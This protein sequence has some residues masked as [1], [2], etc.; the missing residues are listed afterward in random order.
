MGLD[1]SLAILVRQFNK[2]KERIERNTNINTS[3]DEDIEII[4]RGDTEHTFH[5]SS[6]IENLKEL[7]KY[8]IAMNEI[9][10]VK[11]CCSEKGFGFNF[12]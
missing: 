11:Y 4:R 7:V 10:D 12:Y 9:K 5:P 1:K 6:E 3:E 2:N 8:L